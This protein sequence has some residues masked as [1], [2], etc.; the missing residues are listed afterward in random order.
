MFFHSVL[1]RIIV[2]SVLLT[3]CTSGIYY[4]EVKFSVSV[5][6]S[7]T[8]II[9]SALMDIFQSWQHIHLHLH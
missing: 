3:I 7:H 9:L 2:V 6:Q 8:M 4:Y 5:E 1:L